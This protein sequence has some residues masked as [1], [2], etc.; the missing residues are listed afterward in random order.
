MNY[1]E[2]NDSKTDIYACEETNGTGKDTRDGHP[3]CGCIRR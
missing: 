1:G 2:E 3:Y